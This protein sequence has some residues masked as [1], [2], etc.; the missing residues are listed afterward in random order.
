MPTYSFRRKSTGEEF[1][2]IMTI[3]ARDEFTKDPDIVQLIVSAPVLGYNVVTSKPS[4]AFRD[5][6]REIKKQNPR[7][8]INTF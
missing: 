4:D 7:S 5:K 1:T 2:E 6:L 8:T 3:A